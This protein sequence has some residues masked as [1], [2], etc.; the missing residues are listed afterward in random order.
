MRHGGWPGESGV[1]GIYLTFAKLRKWTQAGRRPLLIALE[2]GA[3]I[4]MSSVCSI[5]TCS[6]SELSRFINL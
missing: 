2:V 6:Y 5:L 1:N 3:I 4:V